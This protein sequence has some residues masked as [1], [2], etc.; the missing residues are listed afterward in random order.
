[1]EQ[2]ELEQ[3][4][5]L[6][7][8]LIYIFGNVNEWLK[9]AEAKNAGLFAFAGAAVFGLLSFKTSSANLY[10]AWKA[11]INISVV[12]LLGAAAVSLCSFFPQT[13]RARTKS[14]QQKRLLRYIR[15]T[16]VLLKNK[17][18][19]SDRNNLLFYVELGRYN[20][21]RLI[22]AVGRKYVGCEQEIA[23]A[24]KF[25]LD[26]ANQIVINSRIS[27]RKNYLFK[28][29]V[30]LTFSSLVALSVVA[31]VYSSLGF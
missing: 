21:R 17:R 8:R 6:E 4:K 9:F 19:R 23:L 28:V 3:Q 15:R 20:A 29:A 16:R 10:D 1:M 14:S 13:V 22:C 25:H 30:V 31:L 18:Y 2:T 26:L 12:F 11:G 5:E 24:S 27:T 7:I